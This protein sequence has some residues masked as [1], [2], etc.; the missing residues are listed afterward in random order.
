MLREENLP[1]AKSAETNYGELHEVHH[2]IKKFGIIPTVERRVVRTNCG[3]GTSGK[4]DHLRIDNGRPVCDL[5]NPDKGI[6]HNIVIGTDGEPTLWRPKETDCGNQNVANSSKSTSEES[7][8]LLCKF[9]KYLN[10][11]FFFIKW[12]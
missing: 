4:C 11:L 3:F 12:D 8:P 6:T 1:P 9:R 10:E 2:P 7:D 5:T